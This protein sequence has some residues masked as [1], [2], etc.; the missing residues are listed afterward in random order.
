[1]PTQDLKVLDYGCGP[2]IANVVSVAS[3]WRAPLSVADY[4]E[5]NR[6][7]A[8]QRWLSGDS[9]AFNWDPY[10]KLHRRNTVIEYT[11]IR[12]EVE[13]RQRLLFAEPT[14]VKAHS[15]V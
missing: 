9:T 4:T 10:L 6:F 12:W 8:V 15:L 11:A 5:E 7:H 13:K 3:H 1:M 2:V 14:R